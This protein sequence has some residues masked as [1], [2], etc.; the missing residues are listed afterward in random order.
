MGGLRS[1]RAQVSLRPPGQGM[2]LHTHTHTG[3]HVPMALRTPA[4]VYCPFQCFLFYSLAAPL[5]RQTPERE[6]SGPLAG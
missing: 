1:M 3:L 4:G 6:V 2:R 5:R